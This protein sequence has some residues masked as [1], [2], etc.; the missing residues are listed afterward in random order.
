M[1]MS[2]ISP[3]FTR[4]KDSFRFA[5]PCR[6]DF[7]SVPVKTIPAS[8]SSRISY[9]CLALRFSTITFMPSAFIRQLSR[10]L[11]ATD[12]PQVFSVQMRSYEHKFQS[13]PFFKYYKVRCTSFRASSNFCSHMLQFSFKSLTCVLQEL[14]LFTLFTFFLTF[15]RE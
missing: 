3:F 10:L 13:G 4:A 7:T 8:K 12:F 1:P 11:S 5:F 2:Q 6:S 9:S 14:E 15:P